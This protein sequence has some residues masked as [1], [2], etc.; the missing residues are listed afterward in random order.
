V[1]LFEMSNRI[2]ERLDSVVLPG[3]TIAGELG[4]MRYMTSQAIATALIEQVFASELEHVDFPMGDPATHKFYLRK[5]R[6]LASAWTIGPRLR[7]GWLARAVPS[8]H[9]TVGS[10]G[11]AFPW[12]AFDPRSEPGEAALRVWLGR[13]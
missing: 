8:L 11:A 10:L 13:R 5:Q 4:G 2:G 3:V 7:A 1:A 9:V 6:F 12:S